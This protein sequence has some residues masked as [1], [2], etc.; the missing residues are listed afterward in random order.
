MDQYFAQ[1]EK[2]TADMSKDPQERAQSKGKESKDKLCTRVKFSI[3]EIIDMRKVLCCDQS[4]IL[5]VIQILNII[6]FNF[7][8]LCYERSLVIF[9]T[10]ISW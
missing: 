1:F 5:L 6:H 10:F 3:L 9:I 8:C 2:M 7:P 4:L